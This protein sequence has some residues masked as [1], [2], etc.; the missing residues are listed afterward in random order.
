MVIFSFRVVIF[1]FGVVIFLFRLVIF[2]FL[3]VIF[4]FRVV[5]FQFRVVIFQR[6]NT[7]NLVFC[8]GPNLLVSLSPNPSSGGRTYT[9]YNFIKVS[10]SW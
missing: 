2:L 10:L 4:R 5:I 1:R 7:V 6:K 9:L 3:V 8:F